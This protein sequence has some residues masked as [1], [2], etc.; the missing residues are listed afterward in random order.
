MSKVM[1]ITQAMGNI[2]P[3]ENVLY[4][5]RPDADLLSTLDAL[6][7][8]IEFDKPSGAVFYKSQEDI[9]LLDDDHM[10]EPGW[11]GKLYRG[12]WEPC[13]TAP[14]GVVYVNRTKHIG[15]FCTLRMALEMYFREGGL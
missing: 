1:S 2:V 9:E 4:R 11:W 13:E 15:P 6:H 5:V 12:K 10:K 8:H 3:V 7:A 14:E